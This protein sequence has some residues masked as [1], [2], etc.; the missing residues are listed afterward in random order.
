M[1]SVGSGKLVGFRTGEKNGKKWG[2]VFIDDVDNLM[3]RIQMF[4][5]SDMVDS[6]NQ[7]PIGSEVNVKFHCYSRNNGNEY[8]IRLVEI[9]KK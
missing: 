2:N 3:E 4:V 7:I 9:T 6:V 1:K 5:Q 8:G